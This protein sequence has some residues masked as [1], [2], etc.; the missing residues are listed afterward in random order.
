MK[1]LLLGLMLTSL[2]VT[3]C[4]KQPAEQTTTATTAPPPATTAQPEPATKLTFSFQPS[5]K[6]VQETQ[7]SAA[8]LVA[9][10]A[11]RSGFAVEASF[12]TSYADA[13]KGLKTRKAD[14]VLLSGWAYLKAHH[15]AD[16]DILLVE[17][18]D[19]KASFDAQWFVATDSKIKTL[20]DLKK[21]RIAFTSPTS[22]PGFLL[23][24]AKLIE[25][26][27]L[28]PGADLKKEFAE[29]YFTGG[30]SEALGVLVAGDVDA[31]AGPAFGP[32]LYLKE[33]DQQKVRA[34]ASAPGA[35]THVLAVRSDIDPKVRAKLKEVLLG[36]NADQK[37]LL[38]GALG[39]QK[40][41]ERSHGDHLTVLQNA[42]ELIGAEYPMPEEPDVV[43]DA[44]K[45]LVPPTK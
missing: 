6:P 35:P 7:D 26:G 9:L 41:I 16:A 44:P 32:S 28:K 42:Q 36:L 2:V 27:V 25:D 20:S 45:G 10:I 34:L 8:K 15:A 24:F 31:A 23:P 1:Q 5:E 29:V 14:V 40:L 13:I 19:G 17:E 33:P 43:P 21:K 18:R 39:A 22:A 38:V 4:R 11:E 30:E 37:D 12:P 3:G